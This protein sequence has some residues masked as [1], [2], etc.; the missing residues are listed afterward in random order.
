[1]TQNN[2]DL[3]VVILC[4][5]SGDFASDFV[6]QVQGELNKYPIRY[7]LILVANYKESLRGIDKTPDVVRKIAQINKNIKY[8]AK[9]KKGM[10][11]WDMRSGLNMASGDTIAVIDGDGQM[12][13]KDIV[14]VFNGLRS[15]E[16]DIAKTY[17]DQRYDGVKRVIISRVY[18]FL[19]KILFPKVKVRDVNSKPKIFTRKSLGLLGLSSNDW[20]I[21]A[22]IIIKASYLNLKINELPTQFFPNEQR[23][24]FVGSSTIF[25]FIRNLIVFRFKI[26]KW[27]I[28]HKKA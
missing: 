4:Y 7:E 19:V 27:L 17:R 3:S 20:F 21:D 23:P 12:P 28:N 1:M 22:E 5:R 2:I 18:N 16:Y 26:N 6:E 25:E 24:S 15:G 8:T 9:V 11:G 13:P 14:K 10:M